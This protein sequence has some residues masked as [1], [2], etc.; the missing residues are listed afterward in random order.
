MRLLPRCGPVKNSAERYATTLAAVFVLGNGFH[1]RYIAVH[2][3]VA[4]GVGERHVPVVARRVLWQFSL[5][6]VQVVDQGCGDRIRSE[7][8]ANVRE[9]NRAGCV[10][11]GNNSRLQIP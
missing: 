6:A 1:G 9:S 3:A 10:R 4:N 2:H 5:K 11:F 7:A 8:G